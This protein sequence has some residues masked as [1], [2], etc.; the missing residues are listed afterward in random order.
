MTKKIPLSHGRFATVDDCDFEKAGQ[1]RWDIA[2]GYAWCRSSG[3]YIQLAN[4]IMPPPKGLV[5][6][7]INRNKL[8][9]TRQNLRIATE[10]QNSVNKGKVRRINLRSKYK[11][12]SINLKN[13][14]HYSRW[15]VRITESG[16]THYKGGFR[17][18]EDAAREYDR[19]ALQYF[20]EFASLNFPL[21]QT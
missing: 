17:N 19:I 15:I 8:D 2:E 11:G 14:R 10:K 7:H 6:D 12:V 9:C 20:G 21:E 13:G 3:N 1:M 16:N 18:E 5:I 4:L